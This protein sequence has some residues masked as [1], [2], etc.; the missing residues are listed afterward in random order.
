VLSNNIAM[1]V[2]GAILSAWVDWSTAPLVVWSQCQ[3]LLRSSGSMARLEWG[4]VE[5]GGGEGGRSLERC[6]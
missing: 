3:L 1:G 6:Y 2:N 5:V 4:A